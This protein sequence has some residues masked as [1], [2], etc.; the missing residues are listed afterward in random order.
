MFV[1]PQQPIEVMIAMSIVVSAVHALYPLF[2]DKESYISGAFGLTHGLSFAIVL[3][4]IGTLALSIFGFNLG[5]EL[6]QLFIIAL[7]IPWP[8][9]LSKSPVYK[10]FRIAGAVLSGIAAAWI[11]ERCSVVSTFIAKEYTPRVMADYSHCRICCDFVKGCLSI[12]TGKD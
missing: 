12:L 4:N 11:V 10:L 2:P 5:I 7:I 8:I 9:I 6:M 3:S 1:P